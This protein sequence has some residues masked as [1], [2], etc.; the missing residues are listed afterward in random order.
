[1]KCP[2]TTKLIAPVFPYCFQPATNST[3]IRSFFHDQMIFAHIASLLFYQVL[4][5]NWLC[6]TIALMISV[7]FPLKEKFSDFICTNLQS[8][9]NIPMNFT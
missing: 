1:M 8:Y 5:S 9:F 2:L 3:P 6:A 4:A 7:L